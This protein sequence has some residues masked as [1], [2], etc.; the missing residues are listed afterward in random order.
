MLCAR[1]TLFLC[2]TTCILAASDWP[3][4][5]GPNAFGVSDTT[6]LPSEFG[7]TKNV[8][9]RTALPPGHSS[10]VLSMNRIFL[11]AY[12][13]DH[14]YVMTLERSTGK[15]LWRREL[16][17]TRKQKLHASNSPASPSVATDGQ[18]AYAFFTDSGLVSYGSDGEERW[19][20]PLGPFDNPFGLA[21][22]PVLANGKV[23]QVCDSETGSFV[24]AVDQK[25]GRTA[26]R[27]DRPDMTRGFS[28]PVLYQPR[29]GPLQVL[30]AGTNRFIAYDVETG[31]EVWWVRGLT[32]QMKPT[33]V[34]AGDIA[35]V[36]GW[37][38]GSDQGNQAAVPSFG[39]ILKEA[40]ANHDGKLSKEELADPQ[41]NRDFEDSDLNADGFLEEREWEKY[42]ERRSLVNSVM[43]I[44][45][46]GAGD[47]T[48]KS[49]LW[50]YFKSLPNVPSPLLYQNVLYLMKEGGILTALDPA[51]GSVLKQGRLKGALDFYYS[52]PVGADGKIFTASQDGHVSVIR[53]GRDWEVLAVND[54]DDEVYATPAPVDQQL[55]LRTKSAL[56]CFGKPR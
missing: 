7:P 33:P 31:K 48:E 40:D 4:F 44:R 46:G 39:E 18:N 10:P 22:S 5:R 21:A 47:M 15:I 45:L 26:W 50:R 34:V 49:I 13:E 55:Y 23:I 17:R 28:T 25:S 11:T 9:W 8:V 38:G 53:A 16:P 12:G 51:T 32:W 54:M 3:Q 2:A 29:Q 37:A 14:L 43:A 52:S 27:V 56:Y 1:A 20:V 19:R 41:Y 42:R 6:G 24:I 36:L 30:V 35:Y